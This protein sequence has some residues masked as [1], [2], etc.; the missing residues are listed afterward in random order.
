MYSLTIGNT[1][2][3]RYKLQW[4]S[5]NGKQYYIKKTL[6]LHSTSLQD[7]KNKVLSLFDSKPDNIQK[8]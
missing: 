5:Y 6:V 7:V 3:N 4:Y 8:I 1:V 2:L